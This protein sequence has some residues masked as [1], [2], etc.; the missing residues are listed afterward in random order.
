MVVSNGVKLKLKAHVLMEDTI[1]KG[2]SHR[3]YVVVKVHCR[4]HVLFKVSI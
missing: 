4:V 3:I 2:G 1:A